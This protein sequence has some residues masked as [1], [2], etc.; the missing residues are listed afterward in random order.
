MPTRNDIAMER[1]KTLA[2]C[3]GVFVLAFGVRAWTNT[4]L[5][6]FWGDSYHHWLITRLTILHGGVYSDYKGLEVVWSPLYHYLSTVPL[7][8]TARTDI[9]PLHW[10]NTFWGAT[11]CALA[12]YLAWRIYADRVAALTAGLVLAGMTWHIAFSGMNVA[13]V[14]SGVL[15][16]SVCILVLV[17][18]PRRN[19]SA[20]FKRHLP[21]MPDLPYLCLLFLLAAAM[22]LT[23]T[24]LG[25]YLAIVVLWLWIQRRY[26][27]AVALALG[28]AL[29]LF[30]WSGWS[31]FKTGNWLH[32]YQQYTHN[33]AH[34]WVLLNEAT[35]NASFTFAEYLN[36][37]SP[38]VLPAL[39]GGLAFS[40]ST[41]G[42]QRRA[43]WL[44][45][46]LLAGHSLFLI[47]GYARGIV[48]LLTERYLALDLPLAAVLIGS[49]VWHFGQSFGSGRFMKGFPGKISVSRV[50]RS[51]TAAVLVILVFARFQ[52]DI[53]EL[54]IRRALTLKCR[55]AT[56]SV[57]G[58]RKVK[59]CCQT[60][61]WRYMPAVK[62]SRNLSRRWA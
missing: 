18:Q 2:L 11:A 5:T 57:S 22:F 21:R 7:L 36:R 16:L 9:V 52:N 17:R 31:F 29:A 43:V 44:V 46:A 38:T 56:L 50:V 35:P 10:M 13:E 19:T 55:L 12:A 4:W 39:L 27:E 23:R 45:T 28:A 54:Q 48:P 37:L 14:F 1:L 24:D 62:I 41:Q 20:G 8:L 60:L 34:D 30:G 32:W 58:C 33:N 59:S 47:V 61:R 40:I 49:W 25:V 42:A 3:A 6:D 51:L 53:P 26:A 15:V